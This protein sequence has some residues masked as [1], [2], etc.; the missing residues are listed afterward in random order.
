MICSRLGLL[1]L[2]LLLEQGDS[3]L[4]DEAPWQLVGQAVLVTAAGA[5]YHCVALLS[6]KVRAQRWTFLQACQLGLSLAVGGLVARHIAA[7]LLVP[8]VLTGGALVGQTLVDHTLV[9]VKVLAVNAL[10]WS[11]DLVKLMLQVSWQ[12]GD[13]LLMGHD[14]LVKTVGE[15]I[16]LVAIFFLMTDGTALSQQ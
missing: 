11:D 14:L 16:I 6:H 7:L 12:R 10:W 8:L 15:R 4:V 13:D 3:R 5:L 1:L 2:L 9:K